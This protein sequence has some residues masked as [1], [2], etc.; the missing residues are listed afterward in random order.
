MHGISAEEWI[1]YLDRRL[2]GSAR[3]RIEAHM[4]DCSKCREFYG[5]IES[6]VKSLEAAGSEIIRGLPLGDEKINLS[7]AKIL[8][9]ILD[10]E[11]NQQQLTPAA[12]SERLNHLEELLALMCGSW[13]AAS[14]LRVAAEGTRARSLNH[15]TQDNWASFLERLTSITSVFC[16]TAG[17][18]LVREYGRL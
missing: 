13:T 5:R 17:A 14:V 2:D 9:R 18:R 6:A 16:G 7:L 4:A 3:A 8:A 12:I 10:A 1:D 15:L 11:A